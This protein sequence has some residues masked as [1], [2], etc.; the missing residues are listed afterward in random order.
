ML[1]TSRNDQGRPAQAGRPRGT[2]GPGAQAGASTSGSARSRIVS[3][4]DVAVP[5][6]ICADIL[7]E[8]YERLKKLRQRHADF[9]AITIAGHQLHRPHQVAQWIAAR[10]RTN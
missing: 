7:A 10:S 4:G 3:H 1:N 2:S 6:N 5:L 8:S 9:P